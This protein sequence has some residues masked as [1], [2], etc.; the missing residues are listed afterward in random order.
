M[1]R[2]T[3]TVFFLTVLSTTS[4][5]QLSGKFIEQ[6]TDSLFA[7]YTTGTPGVAVAVV[8][9]G[10]MVFKKGYGSANLEYDIPVTPE[11]VFL[12]GSV[13][14]Q[15]TAFSIYLLEHQGKLSLNDDVRKYIPELSKFAKPV[16]IKHL[17]YHT[18]GLKEQ[19]ALLG[20]SGWRMDEYISNEQI[21]SIVSRQTDL[22]FEPGSKFKYSNTNYTLLAEIVERVSGESFSSFTKKNIFE[23]LGMDNSQFYDDNERLI[24]GRAYSYDHEDSTY[25]KEKLNNVYVG[26]TGLYTT[27]EDLSKW[28]DNFYDPKVGDELLIRKFNQLAT[29]D[30]G[31]PAL[32]VEE[33]KV[34]HAK[35]QFF[36]NYRGIDTYIHTGGDA[37]FK[38]FFGRFPDERLTV[39]VL[40]NDIR[41]VPY[42]NGIKIAEFCLEDKMHPE[43]KEEDVPVNVDNAEYESDKS[44]LFRYSGSF[45][46]EELLTRYTLRVKEGNLVMSHV[47]L[48][49]MKL[50]Q[51]GKSTFSGVNYYPFTVDFIEDDHG[52]VSGL[53]IIDFRGEIISFE[54]C[55][56]YSQACVEK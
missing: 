5:G 50:E 16:T 53:N 18:S 23:P 43:Q 9:E 33:P 35:G 25:K 22:N 37:A 30:D 51:K 49:D 27:V 7:G 44:Q 12:V 31:S 46:S 29:L 55:Y 54:K 38:A 6:K 15:F 4:Y 10:K 28:S 13:S 47:R 8:H 32:L 39:I 24:K 21:L 17:C 3:F 48:N 52:N 41:F 56:E 1:I 45:Y 19:L 20:F 2:S 26:S 40:S 14:K 11:T 42:S 34:Q 36:R